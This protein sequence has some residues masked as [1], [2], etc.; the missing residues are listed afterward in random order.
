M[1]IGII[2]D[3]HGDVFSFKMALENIFKDIDLILHAG[4]ILYHGPRNTLPSGYNPEKLANIINELPTDILFSKGNCDSAVDQMMINMPIL[5]NYLFISIEGYKILLYHGDTKLNFKNID[6]IITGH[7]H[8]YNLQLSDSTIFINPGSLSLPK[9][10]NNGTCA[11][12]DISLNL[13]NIY[14]IS[15]SKSLM[16]AKF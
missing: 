10:H 3:T 12:L 6:F 1:K 5:S 15:S 4:D 16:E 13:I 9:N 14:D 7:T 2:S 8:I 11:I